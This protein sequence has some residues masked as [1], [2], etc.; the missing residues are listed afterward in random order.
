VFP[1]SINIVPGDVKLTFELRD[2]DAARID[3][4]LQSI[5]AEAADIAEANRVTMEFTPRP[6]VTPMPSH[7]AVLQQIRESCQALGFD[8]GMLPSGAGHDA[9][10]IGRIA[11]MGMIFVP[12][13]GGISHSPEEFTTAEDCARGAEVLLQTIL[14]LDRLGRAELEGAS[15]E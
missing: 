6:S 14:R 11:P 1:N 10:M 15:Q 9:Q 13:A 2:I 5:H 8:Y 12:S 3:A 7:P 4:A